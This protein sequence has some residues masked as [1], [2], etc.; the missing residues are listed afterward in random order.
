[1]GQDMY[2]LHMNSTFH[3]MYKFLEATRPISDL[4]IFV[5][6]QPH[7]PIQV[8]KIKENQQNASLAL[9]KIKERAPITLLKTLGRIISLLMYFCGL[10][11]NEQEL[12]Y[13]KLFVSVKNGDYDIEKV[14][15]ERKPQTNQK[16]MTQ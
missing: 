13:R 7:G 8:D 16:Q 2:G 11:R 15:K 5:S 14:C 4:M 1:M 3:V 10:L 12:F 6:I 9:E